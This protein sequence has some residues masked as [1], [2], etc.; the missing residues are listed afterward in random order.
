MS[1]IGLQE[2]YN[3]IR[4]LIQMA[5]KDG[6]FNLAELTYIVWVSQK[7]GLSKA[8]LDELSSEKGVYLAPFAENERLDLLYQLIKIMYVDG[9]VVEAELDH[10]NDLAEKMSINSS[11]TESLITL[12]KASPNK[13]M[14]RAEFDAVYA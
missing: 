11:K 4:I 3:R 10:F 13:L 12:I 6:I 8:E 5:R 14:E 1:Y 9:E 2:K 7:L